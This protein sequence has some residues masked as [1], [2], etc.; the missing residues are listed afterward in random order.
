[1]ENMILDVAEDIGECALSMISEIGV[2]K[3]EE[4]IVLGLLYHVVEFCQGCD[5]DGTLVTGEELE[6]VLLCPFSEEVFPQIRRLEAFDTLWE[7]VSELITI[8]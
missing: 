5:F 7:Y 2:P 4:K 8:H 1:M 6:G 3:E